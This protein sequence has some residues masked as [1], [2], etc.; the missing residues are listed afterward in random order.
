MKKN[1][2]IELNKSILNSTQTDSIKGKKSI[3]NEEKFQIIS[4]NNFS[5]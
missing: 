4:E 3:D 5:I 2:T 1:Q